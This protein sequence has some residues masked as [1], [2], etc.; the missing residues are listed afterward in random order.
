MFRYILISIEY[1]G[2][3]TLAVAEQFKARFAAD[4]L[5]ELLV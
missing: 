4:H 3:T 5:L 2:N 1:I